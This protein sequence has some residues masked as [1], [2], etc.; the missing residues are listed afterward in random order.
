MRSGGERHP[1]PGSSRLSNT[2][3]QS[4]AWLPAS[5][6]L[7][8][9]REGNPAACAV[10]RRPRSEPRGKARL[11]R[12][13]NHLQA[14]IGA[15]KRCDLERK[16]AAQVVLAAV[17]G[18]IVERQHDDDRRR[19]VRGAR[20]PRHAARSLQRGEQ[21][22]ARRDVEPAAAR[23]GRP[24]L[25]RSESPPG[26]ETAGAVRRGRLG[27]SRRRVAARPATSARRIGTPPPARSRSVGARP[28]RA[29]FSGGAA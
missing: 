19:V 14:G 25:A 4:A 26:A 10:R 11:I 20:R 16:G 2:C 28:D 7:A 29:R 8:V 3:D 21:R 27:R 22:Q 15:Q 12:L 5:Y 18:E 6:R 1:A 13:R 17:A 24:P 23:A 9:T